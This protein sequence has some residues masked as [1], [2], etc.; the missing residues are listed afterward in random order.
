MSYTV[1]EVEKAIREVVRGGRDW[2]TLI[3]FGIRINL[4]ST[5]VDTAGRPLRPARVTIQDVAKG[6]LRH[7][8]NDKSLRE[9]VRVIHGGVGLVEFE[10]GDSR[11][12]EALLDILWR[13]SF[14][15][16]ISEETH[17]NVRRLLTRG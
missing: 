11:E 1:A 15:E 10:F 8:G 9:W 12:A 17:R 3:E 14:G 5:A 13:A 2:R 4:T 7:S 6:W 16:P